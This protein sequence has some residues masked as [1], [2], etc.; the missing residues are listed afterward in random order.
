MQ[1]AIFGSSL[2]HSGI[3]VWESNLT[4]VVWRLTGHN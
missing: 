1:L 4:P 3:E 2:N